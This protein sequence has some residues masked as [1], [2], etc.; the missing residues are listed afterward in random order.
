MQRLHYTMDETGIEVQ[1]DTAREDETKSWVV[2]SRG[3]LQSVAD[4]VFAT[5]SKA[6][7]TT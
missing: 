2:I 4:M 7:T 1:I 5:R 6:K 3:T